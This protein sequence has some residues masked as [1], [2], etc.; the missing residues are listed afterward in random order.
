MNIIEN[1]KD[2]IVPKAIKPSEV[3]PI[4]K[5]RA[6]ERRQKEEALARKKRQTEKEEAPTMM[7]PSKTHPDYKEIGWRWPDVFQESD[8]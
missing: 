3:K 7:I 4:I 1:S 2:Y 5:E 8:F 6:R